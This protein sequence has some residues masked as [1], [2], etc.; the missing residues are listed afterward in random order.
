VGRANFILDNL[1]AAKKAKPMVVIM[2]FG[3]T[4]AVG[5]ENQKDF[6]DD[7]MTGI[8]PYAE[9]HYRVYT[10]RGHRAIAGLSMGGSQTMNISMS[11]L[12]QFA[13]VGVFSSGVFNRPEAGAVWEKDHLATLDN[14]ALKKD[15]KV[16][17]FKTGVDDPLL[18]RSTKPTVGLLEKHGFKVTSGQSGGAHVWP[19]WRDYL[20][21]FAPLL[22]Q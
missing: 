19:N 11:H 17:W 14:A 16:V 22:F 7:F 15:L 10:D 5:T 18:E 9:S 1:I 4:T 20:N 21:E 3:H 2:P 8:M 6:V 13:Y 12:D